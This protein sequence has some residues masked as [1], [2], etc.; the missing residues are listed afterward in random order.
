MLLG[1]ALVEAGNSGMRGHLLAAFLVPFDGAVS[2]PQREGSVRVFAGAFE[3]KARLG[4]LGVGLLFGFSLG[5]NDL[6][7]SAR[8]GI[9]ELRQRNHRVFGAFDC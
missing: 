3:S 7:H 5:L 6:S 1:R 4:N 2:Q 9:D 8:V